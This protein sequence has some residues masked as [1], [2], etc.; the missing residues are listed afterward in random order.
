MFWSSTAIDRVGTA[1]SW[2]N[3]SYN[4]FKYTTDKE[5]PM[6]FYPAIQWV[7]IIPIGLK[8]VS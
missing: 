4:L 2:N 1:N 7:L 8:E 3:K 5:K 6:W